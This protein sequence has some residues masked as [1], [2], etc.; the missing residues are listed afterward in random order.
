MDDSTTAPGITLEEIDISNDP[1]LLALYQI[2]IP[3]LLID[4]KRRRGPGDEG[5]AYAGGSGYLCKEN[6]R[7][8]KE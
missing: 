1:E 8:K 5:G 6:G 3:V 4:G 7:W 2:E